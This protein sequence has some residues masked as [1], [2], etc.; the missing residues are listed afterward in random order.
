MRL[1]CKI[2]IHD[3][4]LSLHRKSQRSILAFIKDP[5]KNNNIYLYLQTRQ[6]KHGTKYKIANNITKVFNKFIDDGKVTIS[7]KEPCHDII[8]QSDA[9]QLKSFLNILKRI[10]SGDYSYITKYVLKSDTTFSSNEFYSLQRVVVKKKSEYPILQGFPQMTTQLILSGLDRKSFD[11]QIL[12]LQN[13]KFLDLSNNKISFLPTELGTLPNLQALNLSHNNLGKSVHSKWTWLEQ[14]PLRNNL[15]FLDISN[16]LL[17]KLPIQIGLLDALRELNIHR[18]KLTKL[19]Q[20]IGT[21]SK[22]QLLNVANNNLLFLPGTIQYLQLQVLDISENS[23]NNIREELI[24]IQMDSN[25]GLPS[26]LEI[27]ARSILKSRIT[28][29]ASLIP[30]TLVQYLYEAKYCLSCKQACFE[31]YARILRKIK[32]SQVSILTRSTLDHHC[33][34]DCYFCSMKCH[35]YYVTRMLTLL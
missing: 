18:N 5:V 12:T 35:N 29:D 26:L 31:Y 15:H 28:Y 20:N 16:N 3:K 24:N 11:R 4:T 19:P 13:L 21:L 33:L 10:T 34:L 9:F 22:L 7:L 27:S 25:K 32:L 17:T 6:N 2:E 14:T 23:F 30:Y 8:I 1:H